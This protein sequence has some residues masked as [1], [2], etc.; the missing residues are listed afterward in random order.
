ML[1]YV[2]TWYATDLSDSS[3]HLVYARAYDADGNIS[4][5]PVVKVLVMLL[6]A[7]TNLS[8]QLLNDMQIL[9][10]WQDNSKIE[11]G[12][13][14][15]RK[16]EGSSYVQIAE[17]GASVTSYEDVGLTYGKNYFYRV[18]AYNSKKNSAYSNEKS[19]TMVIPAPINLNLTALDDQSVHLTWTDN[20]TFES[21]FRIERKEE[22]GNYSQIAEVCANVTTY[23][24][25][26]LTYG[27][28]YTYRIRAYTQINQ[29]GYSNENSAKVIIPVPTNLSA[30]SIDDQTIKLTWSDNCSFEAGY[31]IECKIGTGSFI[32]IVEL[33]T[34]TTEYEE[35]DLTYGETYTY[36]IRAFTDLNT[37]EYSNEKTAQWTV[38]DIDG[39][40]Y[41]TV[42]IGNQIWFAE[43]L[44]VTHYRNGDAIPYV[45]D[46]T[47]WG[48][49]T[50]GAYCNYNNDVNNST[51]YGH[52]YN[53]YAVTDS[54]NIAPAGWHIP[55]DAEWQT[56][57]D[58]LGGDAVA[59]GKMKETG[60][61]HWRSPNTGATNESG[62][63]ALPGGDRFANGT[64]FD[65]VGSRGY[66][67]SS[68][69]YGSSCAESRDL[70]YG[71][72]EVYR[73]T[74]D[75]HFGFSV[76]CVRD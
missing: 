4:T 55:T 16:E 41:R 62:F 53:W 43:N 59:G 31:R 38:T 6:S 47:T 58:Y 23:D 1:P 18:R 32:Q 9:L 15:E 71:S 40:I 30:T 37:S 39:N 44:K 12:F 8:A 42:K 34:N 7:P 24:D 69:E 49:L 17:V 68:T 74:A 27:E 67:W 10:T 45:T 5:T 13:R 63:S 26:G 19:I 57:V 65:Y 70:N 20:C 48:D 29:S 75:G 73:I 36:R 14:I 11:D 76:R 60:T 52:L 2:Y 50:T 56:L 72:S 46:N 28:I 61:I 54:R 3:D 51:T 21:G 64:Y 22:G 66:W 25:A 33:S 35:T